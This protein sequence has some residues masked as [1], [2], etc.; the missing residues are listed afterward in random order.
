VEKKVLL[1]KIKEFSGYSKSEYSTTF[2]FSRKEQILQNFVPVKS[3]VINYNAH[4][5]KYVLF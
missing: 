1:P 5:Y 3:Y 2:P 4:L